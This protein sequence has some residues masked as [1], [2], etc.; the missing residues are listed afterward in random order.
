MEDEIVEYCPNCGCAVAGEL[1]SKDQLKEFGK[2]FLSGLIGSYIGDKLG[3][4]GYGD[5]SRSLTEGTY[6]LLSSGQKRQVFEFNCPNC[7]YLWRSHG[8]GGPS[9]PS[10]QAGYG[11]PGSAQ[12]EIDNQEYQLFSDEFTRFFENED[13]ILSSSNSL[14]N[15]VN[16]LDGIIKSNIGN[17]IVKSEYRFLQAFACSEYLYYIDTSDAD[18][19][20]QGER[21]IDSAIQFFNDYEYKVLKQILR[22]YILDFEAPDILSIQKSY[23]QKCPNIQELQNTLINTE[24][25]DQVYRFSRFCSLYYTFRTLDNRDRCVQAIDALKLMLKLDTP[26]AYVTASAYLYE[27]HFAIEKY[28]SFWDEEKAFRYAKQGADYAIDYMKSNYSPDD[29]LSKDWMELVVGTACRYHDGIGIEVDLS[30]AERYLMIGVGHGDEECKKLLK[31]LYELPSNNV[32]NSTENGKEFGCSAFVDVSKSTTHKNKGHQTGLSDSEIEYLDTL[33]ES[34]EDGEITPRERKMLDRIRISL[35]I[36]EKRAEELEMALNNQN[37]ANNNNPNSRTT[38]MTDCFVNNL[39]STLININE[40][41]N[42]YP[43]I[44]EKTQQKLI[45]KFGMERNEAV[46]FYCESGTLFKKYTMALT[47]RCVYYKND[48]KQ[49]N[50][51]MWKDVIDVNC[52]STIGHPEYVDFHFP[53]THGEHVIFMTEFGII[54]KEEIEKY[55]ESV[56]KG[57][58]QMAITAKQW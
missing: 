57:L 2:G 21:K 55:L 41:G 27:F 20:K 42:M 26:L 43:R 6:S 50:S 34:F 40:G 49:I 10:L 44:S 51:F 12:E 7:G 5:V 9:T 3:E 52:V 24:Y 18:I 33:K 46:L 28:K 32:A 22:S 1:P 53:T 30:E 16:K 35:G 11:Q 47:D 58:K 56:R 39:S 29:Q 17:T 14:M 13:S 48:D 15:Y 38:A 54:Y 25:L 36:S 45:Y 19:A 37:P 8:L 4:E 31:E 23:D